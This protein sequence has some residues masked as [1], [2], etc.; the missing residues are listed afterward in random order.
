VS[1]RNKAVV[2]RF[3]DEWINKHDLAAFREV[4]AP[5]LVFHWGALGEGRS[6]EEMRVKEEAA[7]E[8]FPD[9]EATGEGMLAEDDLVVERYTV[10][11]TH[12]GR[13]FGVEPTGKRATW[14][15]V[16][17]YRIENGRIAEMWLNEDWAGVL[18]QVGALPS[19]S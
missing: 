9:L 12:R 2:R 18:Q 5:D 4:A 6:D 15:A 7:R 16:A 8:A 13:W 11:G 10:T 3:I 19:A 17:T 1:E 14:T